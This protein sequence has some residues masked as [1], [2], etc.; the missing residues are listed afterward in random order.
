M[1]SSCRIPQSL[2]WPCTVKMRTSSSACATWC[3]LP[4]ASMHRSWRVLWRVSIVFMALAL[5]VNGGWYFHSRE[6]PGAANQ[7]P[8]AIN[9]EARQQAQEGA[10]A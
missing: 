9:S 10:H 8:A 6:V 1:S 2:Q 5:S 7:V 4:C 3:T